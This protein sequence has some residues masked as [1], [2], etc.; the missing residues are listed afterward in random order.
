MKKIASTFFFCFFVLTI[1]LNAQKTKEFEGVI[2]YSHQVTA[3]SPDYNTERDYGYIGKESDFYYKAGK[4]KWLNQ[5]AFMQM[6]M[7]RNA[8]TVEFLQMASTD[9]ILFAKNNFSNEKILDYKIMKN[10]DTV[11]G[12]VCNVLIL[13]AVSNGNEWTRRYSYS[14]N[15]S[16]DPNFFKNYKYNSTDFIYATIKALPLKIELIYKD[17]KITYT[18]TNVQQK[19]IQDNFFEFTSDTKFKSLM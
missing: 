4:Y 14:T 11:L 8:D 1:T 12:Q 16:I 6:D 2:T 10:A 19:K 5:N 13:K 15:T 9:T 17:R 3:I 18:A 7:F